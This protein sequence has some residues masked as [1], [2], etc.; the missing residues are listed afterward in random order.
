MYRL[1]LNWASVHRY[2]ADGD[3]YWTVCDVY[4]R[5][6]KTVEETFSP[7]GKKIVA[8]AAIVYPEFNLLWLDDFPVAGA[9][10]MSV[11][12]FEKMFASLPRWKS[13]RYACV[14]GVNNIS[15]DNRVTSYAAML[16]DCQTGKGL[17]RPGRKRFEVSSIL[18]AGL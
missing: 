11:D 16:C 17:F 9:E 1:E 8:G 4:P 13:T 10:E 5:N 12:D 15:D 18:R 14:Y 6:A 7:I 2:I 3:K